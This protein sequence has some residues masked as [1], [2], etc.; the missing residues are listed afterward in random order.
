MKTQQE[1]L[2]ELILTINIDGFWQASDF[3]ILF[4]SIDKLYQFYALHYYVEQSIGF[5][6]SDFPRDT[7]I[8]N[9]PTIKDY[10]IFLFNNSTRILKEGISNSGIDDSMLQIPTFFQISSL[11]VTKVKFNSPGS[12]DFL[13]LGKILEIIKDVVFYYLPNKNSKKHNYL[14][15]KEI[16]LKEQE[17]IKLK[18]EN[19]RNMGFPNSQIQTII[20]L[21][22]YHIGKLKDFVD[23]G[24][25]MN[26]EIVEEEK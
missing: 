19:L 15:D 26:A 11:Q 17:I 10:R 23:S 25:V 12:I 7:N 14:L 5:I 16:E 21:E 4:E 3:S 22:Y 24:Q 13:G 6:K 20:G 2:E 18:V 8:Y 9:L 1:T